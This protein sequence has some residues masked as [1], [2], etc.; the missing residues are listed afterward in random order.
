ML[1][2]YF[3]EL[4]CTCARLYGCNAFETVF[5]FLLTHIQIS[6]Y[7]SVWLQRI[8]IYHVTVHIKWIIKPVNYVRLAGYAIVRFCSVSNVQ[9]QLW[10]LWDGK[11]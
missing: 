1:R 7:L 3:I 11:L 10:W 4:S 5:K 9:E 8:T 2:D 6:L